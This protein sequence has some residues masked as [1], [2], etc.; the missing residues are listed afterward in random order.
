MATIEELRCQIEEAK[1]GLREDEQRCREAEDD[2]RQA[3]E[4]Q[5]L[6]RQLAY[7]NS[8]RADRQEEKSRKRRKRTLID[9]DVMNSDDSDAVL[10]HMIR[11]IRRES[12]KQSNKDGEINVITEVCEGEY[13]WR[14]RG[15]SWL[16]NAMAENGEDFVFTPDFWVGSALFELVY[17]PEPVYLGDRNDVRQV[18]SLAIRHRQGTGVIFRYKLFIKKAG[19]DFVQWGETANECH[20]K[21]DTYPK[22]FGPDVQ[23]WH[24]P[25]RQPFGIFGLKHQDLLKSEWVEHDT[26]TVKLQAE[27]LQD[28]DVQTTAG[29]SPPAIT[30]PPPNLAANLLSRL[31]DD[32]DTDLTFIVDGQHIKAHSQIVSAR[33]EVFDKELNS[34]M[35]ES[36]SKII[37]V[38][39]S[40]AVCFDQF[41]RFLY[42]DDLDRVDAMIRGK[43]AEDGPA[44]S[45]NGSDGSE[46][47]SAVK[48]AP[49]D[50]ASSSGRAKPTRNPH[51]TMLQ[52]LLSISHRYQ[53]NRL[54]LWCQ[55]QLAEHICKDHVCSLLC[56]AHLFEAKGLETACLAYIK[57][58]LDS[59][60]ATSGFGSLIAEWPEVML[61][62]NIFLAGLSESGALPAIEA[63]KNLR[64]K[65]A[66]QRGAAE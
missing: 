42:T 32:R 3:F 54:S 11:R 53:V 16:Q 47:G 1:R 58:N 31:T 2:V 41:L 46:D 8:C 49:R 60:A 61:K 51:V 36:V 63:H 48:E 23:A 65:R 12:Q 40:D 4:R 44:I 14:L 30:V 62:L 59:V 37:E 5:R 21:W 33:S 34:G 20:P 57:K 26:L 64:K 19:G 10:P 9:E 17:A 39:G 24:E 25:L 55:Q 29:A 35:R 28:S 66:V 13:L 7:I 27:V 56:Q 18:G 43:L 52:N 22:P 15:M 6:R 45:A 38:H 50:S